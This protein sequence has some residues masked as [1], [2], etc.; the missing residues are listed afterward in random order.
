MICTPR[1]REGTRSFRGTK[2]ASGDAEGRR[3]HERGRCTVWGTGACR[4]ESDGNTHTK[5]TL[6][7]LYRTSHA[8]VPGT[9]LKKTRGARSAN[10]P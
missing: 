10:K 9:T 6:I 8:R 4:K 2:D 3:L 1:G 5:N 7:S